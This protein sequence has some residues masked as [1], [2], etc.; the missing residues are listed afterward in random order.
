MGANT[1]TN[2]TTGKPKVSG[3]VYVAP[4]GT[5]LP[6]DATTALAGDYI[7]LGYVSDAGLENTNDLNI[8]TI[9]EWGGLVVYQSLDEFVDQFKLTLIEAKSV[10]V[11]KAAYGDDNVTEDNGTIHVVVNA[12]DPQER[13]WVFELA[14]RGGIAKRIVVADG[15]VTGRDAITYTASDAVGYG[16]TISAYPD[17]NGKTHDEYIEASSTP[18]A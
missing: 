15:A 5:A 6:T 7:N 4:K 10:N 12:D 16:L 1:A 8:S 18:S 11:L 13:V 2:V 9:K 17:A 14:L 3:A